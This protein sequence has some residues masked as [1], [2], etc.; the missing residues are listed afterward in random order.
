MDVVTAERRGAG[1]SEGQAERERMC[2]VLASC[3][4]CGARPALRV[5]A[6]VVERL[7]EEDP[8]RRV[9]SYQCQ[10]RSCGTIYD[11]PAGAVRDPE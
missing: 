11:I 5:S 7:R 8:G 1:M 2:R 4:A 6:W 3:P 9:A 10:R